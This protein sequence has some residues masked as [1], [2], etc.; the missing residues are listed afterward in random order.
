MRLLVTRVGDKRHT[1]TATALG[2][3]S[4]N[5]VF[6]VSDDHEVL[7]WNQ[8]ASEVIKAF[9]LPDDVY[10]T[11]MQWLPVTQAGKRVQ[12]DQYAVASADGKFRLVS[13]TGRVE[14]TVEAHR[15]AV[16]DLRWSYDGSALLTSGEDGQI[17]IWSRAGMLRS[18]LAQLPVPVYSAA[19]S[20]NSDSV[21]HTNGKSLVIKPLQPASK[22]ETVSWF[23][24]K[25]NA[26]LTLFSSS[27]RRMKV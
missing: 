3:A 8:A 12:S 20:P 14:K 4:A 25:S 17:K 10:P 15:G 1:D 18:S 24:I 9:S 19:W 11:A 6:S 22:P 21:V 5:E 27:G 13:R 16:T 23:L 2:W 26:I 7:K